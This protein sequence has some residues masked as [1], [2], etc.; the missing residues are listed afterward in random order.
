MATPAEPRIEEDMYHVYV[1]VCMSVDVL[2]L[3]GSLGWG[4]R[5]TWS[6]LTEDTV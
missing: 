5:K 1:D 3:H 4:G 6:L 2:G